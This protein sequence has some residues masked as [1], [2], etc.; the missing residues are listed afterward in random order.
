MVNEVPDI[1]QPYLKRQI[2]YI[3]QF[4]RSP[5]TF[6]SLV[7]SSPWLCN[8]MSELADWDQVMAIAELGAGDGVL[9]IRLLERLS[10][11]GILDA[12]E[13]QPDL[14]NQL[15]LLAGKDPRLNVISSSAER[16]YRDYDL[17]FSCLPLLSIS[18]I[19]CL[20]ILRQ[21]CKH[22]TPEGRFILFQYTPVTEKL[23]SRYFVWTKVYEFRNFPPA[24][25]YTCTPR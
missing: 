18:R 5:K 19:T 10:S 14:V 13:I 2:N 24:W 15:Q 1:V 21:V 17:I 22:L 9:T 25:I 16:L 7:P 23:L 12:Y 6:G 20:R 11:E 8:R 3:R 4:L